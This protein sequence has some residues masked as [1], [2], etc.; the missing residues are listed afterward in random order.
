WEPPFRRNALLLVLKVTWFFLAKESS[1]PA[2]TLIS[3]MSMQRLT[4]LMAARPAS[5]SWCPQW[6]SSASCSHIDF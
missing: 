6:F 4:E 2:A 3:A 1:S 5:R